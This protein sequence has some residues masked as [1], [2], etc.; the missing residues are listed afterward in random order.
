M[1]SWIKTPKSVVPQELRYS[2]M[3]SAPAAEVKTTEA[4]VEKP[5]TEKIIHSEEYTEAMHHAHVPAMALSLLVALLGILTA[6]FLYRKRV[7]DV[8]KLVG[9]I[10]PLYTFSLNKWYIDEFYHATFIAF[11]MG[12]SKLLAWFDAR[13]VDGIVDGSASLTRVFST[14][15]NAFDKYVVDGLVNFTAIFSGLIGIF[16]RKIQTGKVQT[17]IVMVVFS[18]IVMLFIFIY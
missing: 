5:V 6:Y 7:I 18:L 11:T 1:D 4:A 12:L 13:I 3:K 17:Y 15:S 2:F 8:D 9:K 16:V 10:K 14:I